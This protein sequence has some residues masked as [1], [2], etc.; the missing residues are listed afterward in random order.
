MGWERKRGKLLDLNQLLRGGYDSFPVKVGDLSVLPRHPVRDHAR[1][2]Y[3]AAA[4][5]GAPL[6]R[7]DRASAESRRARSRHEDGGRGLRHSAAAHR[8]QHRLR[9]AQ[10]F[11][12]ASTRA[13]PV[14]TF[15]PAR[16]PTSIRICSARASSPAR[17]SMTWTPSAIRSSSAF[18]ENT[19][20]S[21]DLIEGAFARA[22]LVSDI[23]LIDDYP[24]H[25]SAYN[26]RKHRWMRGDWQILRWIMA[27]VPD[28][29][30]N[31]VP[32]SR[33]P[34]LALEDS[35]QSAPQPVRAGDAA[36]AALRLVLPARS[37]S[38]LDPGEHR[39]AADA[40]LLGPALR[41][42][43][44]AVGQAGVSRLGC[45]RRSRPSRASTSSSSCI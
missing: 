38:F 3:P 33:Q 27:R 36:A 23:E 13:R 10:L 20:L 6:R 9:V 15:T 39:D 19:L 24:S 30:G 5:R 40:R 42:Y 12:R 43:S 16:S 22:A 45:G 4:R 8:R 1:L 29:D 28:R 17:A 32:Q 11:S 2:R 25:F 35:R 34:H 14:S 31:L 37:G 21:H 44:C 26:K 18:P 41:G 7:R